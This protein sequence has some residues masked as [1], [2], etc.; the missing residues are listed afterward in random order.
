MSNSDERP[1]IIKPTMDATGVRKGAEDVKAT[2]RDM[3]QAVGAEGRKAG[4]GMEQVGAGAGKG[5][6]ALDRETR[7]MVASIQRAQA[8][9]Q[10][11]GR[12]TAEFYEAIAKQ[13]GL[14]GDALRPYIEGLRAAET[15]Q[16]AATG[17]LGTMGISAKQTAAALRG[18]PA[19]FTDIFTSLQGGQAPL[20]VFLQQG[21][22]LKDM[23]GGAGAA[24]QALGGY[25]ASLIT[26]FT[27]LAAGVGALA[28]GF[29]I[30]KKESDAYAQSLILSGNAAGT[31]VGKLSDMARAIAE[32][33]PATQGK[34][35]EVLTQLAAAGAVGAT[36]LQ[37]FAQAAIDLER[38]G[39]PAAEETAKAFA[40]LAKEPLAASI[41][42]TESTRYL[43]AATAEQI[44]QLERQ[45][46]TTEA[47]RV[48]QEAYA[49][50]VEQRAPEMAQRL[51]LIQGAW[52]GIKDATKGAGDALVDIFRQ[53]TL[54]QQLA[55]AEAAISAAKRLQ[56]NAGGGLIAVFGQRQ[57]QNARA[58]KDLLLEQ[59]RLSTR[60]AEAQGERVRQEQA[61][62]QFLKEGEKYLSQEVKFQTEIVRIREL[63]RAA[64][65]S[66]LAIADR[67]REVVRQ[68]YGSKAA[69]ADNAAAREQERRLEAQVRL[70]AELSGV[71]GSYASDLASLDAAR[72]RGNITEE[73][74]GVLVRELVA[75]QPIVRQNTQDM[76][77]AAEEQARAVLRAQK[78][79][80]GY[81]ETLNN[82][83]KAGERNLL[84]LRD[85]YIELT[86]GKAVR[87]ELQ[88]LEL[89]RLAITYDQAAAVAELNGEEQARYQR[90]AEQVRQEIR[91]RRD[92]AS[93]TDQ[94]DAR[95]ANEKAA[96]D[97][98]ADWKRSAD[99]ISQSLA[100]AIFSG[101]KGAGDLLK[102]YFRTLVLKPVIET[103]MRPL[104]LTIN[105]ALSGGLS[106]AGGLASL[107]GA[108]GAGGA[109]SG[110]GL[111]GTLSS[112][113]GVFGA[114]LAAGVGNL[115]SGSIGAALS[116]SGALLGGGS[117]AAG[118]G[119]GLGALGPL[120]LLAGPLSS[121]LFGRKLKDTGFE[122]SFS[123][124]GDF[125]GNNYRYYKGGL[126]RSNKTK[127]SELDGA[128]ESVLDAGGQAALAQ[129]K[130]Y[131]EVLGL[132]VEALAGYTQ[133]IKVS[134][135]GLS[136][137]EAQAAVAK[138]VA[139]FQ[140]GLLG[141]YSR[142]LEPLRRTGET[143]AQVAE[144][145]STLQVFT[146]GL[147][148]LGGV[149]GRVAG[150]S[151]DAREQLIQLAGGMEQ[152]S[153]QALGFVQQ[154]YSREEI[155]GLK[156]REIQTVLAAAGITQDVNT[157]D[158]FRGL[159]DNTDVSSAAGRER[160]AQLLAIAGDFASVADYL[161]ETG[162][163]LS[164]AAAFAP[165]SGVLADLF[166]QPQQAQV[167]AIN[168]VNVSVNMVNESINR[169][170]DAVQ[171][172]R[173]AVFTPSW[174][175]GGA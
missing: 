53:D 133:A 65:L 114:G 166:A 110:I 147:N 73:R 117:I 30:A 161:A 92:I 102:D 34:A 136:E 17:S 29:I 155:A 123:A 15:A 156:A 170:I 134:L 84:Q 63:G 175:V 169:L 104:A 122:G 70:L 111:L 62:I 80:D 54:T 100:D 112:V 125:E 25:V 139:D 118:L 90:L 99:Q 43:S 96:K 98:A 108:S 113:T 2:A 52:I 91:W 51:N 144:R 59:I 174:E 74:Y 78:V 120:A 107:A 36:N 103:A 150:L 115:L 116:G 22:Q 67:I 35:A 16:K 101:G 105:T 47:A 48:A 76:A 44:Q 49:S 23:F 85:E 106:S 138:S 94:K 19:Q 69:T 71:T 40:A 172:A 46:K 129:A 140:E 66:E 31:T 41:K 86:A 93:A 143:L 32:L 37:R 159:V 68:T 88:L 83:V 148:E 135:K 162:G 152:L 154:Y 173:N 55:L 145:V 146:R 12:N 124:G 50:A 137:E 72:A 82:S 56:E 151:I 127:R 121:A 95:D 13:R 1:V 160:L 171:S 3:A 119:L 38:A 131:A 27:L 39:G 163:T 33:G 11:G 132:P 128:L 87:Q 58:T 97:A 14:S 45:G 61:G 7:R 149:F 21:G 4:E 141:R 20:T 164:A 130:A 8:A 26:P 24:A 109:L 153:Q 126:F 6:Q 167:D 75:R 18:V 60:A 158:Q 165:A 28:A 81:I 79:Y 9:A 5:A 42:L 77:K 157:R 64:G 142:Q 57:E 168:V 10:A 89:E